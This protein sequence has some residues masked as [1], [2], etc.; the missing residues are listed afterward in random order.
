MPFDLIDKNRNGFFISSD[1][2]T[3]FGI[4]EVN[5]FR[6]SPAVAYADLYFLCT[7]IKLFSK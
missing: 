4:K 6:Y 1:Q 2:K 3:R 7:D 5:K